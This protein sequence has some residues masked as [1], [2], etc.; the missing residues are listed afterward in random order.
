MSRFSR[1]TPPFYANSLALLLI[2]GAL[3][4][5]MLL[6]WIGAQIPDNLDFSDGDG[7]EV[8]GLETVRYF[9]LW[10]SSDALDQD[11]QDAGLGEMA[12][13]MTEI[14]FDTEQT[15]FYILLLI[16]VVL[17]IGLFLALL[18]LVRPAV[19]ADMRWILLFCGSIVAGITLAWAF[20]LG[21]LAIGRRGFWL[22]SASGLLLMVQPFILRRGVGSQPVTIRAQSP[23]PSPAPVAEPAV[24]GATPAKTKMKA[25]LIESSTGQRFTLS[26]KQTTLGRATHNHVVSKEITVSRQHAMIQETDGQYT[27]HDQASRH[28]TKVDGTLVTDPVVLK[29]QSQIVLGDAAIYQFELIPVE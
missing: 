10:N 18:S 7:Y 15:D 23:E 22:V 4:A 24:K 3:L 17:V 11:L 2:V 6:P 5:F 26:F 1:L 28:G 27:L 16:P 29:N 25:T 21:D 13:L 12:Q 9:Y 20:R 14:Q 8:T 19:D